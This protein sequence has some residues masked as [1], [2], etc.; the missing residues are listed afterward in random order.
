MKTVAI[1][2]QITKACTHRTLYP[3]CVRVKSRTFLFS[4]HSSWPTPHRIASGWK[5]LHFQ[6]FPAY[7]R[8]ETHPTWTGLGRSHPHKQTSRTCRW[9][10]K[11]PIRQLAREV[12]LSNRRIHRQ[13]FWVH[14][15]TE[16]RT[17]RWRGGGQECVFLC[18][19][20]SCCNMVRY[21]RNYRY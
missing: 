15:L 3:I 18:C 17:L 19:L 11:H 16:A 20:V 7:W 14:F 2:K 10:V 4:M 6:T 13:R 12:P 21:I 8:R 9:L 1:K 5:N